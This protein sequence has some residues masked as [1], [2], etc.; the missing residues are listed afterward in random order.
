[1]IP[2]D[3]E[4]PPEI[5]VFFNKSTVNTYQIEDIVIIAEEITNKFIGG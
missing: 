5:K 1:L 3:D 4:F 2:E